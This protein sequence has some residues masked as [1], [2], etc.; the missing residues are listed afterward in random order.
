[1]R[2]SIIRMLFRNILVAKLN[3]KRA[4][5]HCRE[6]V[7]LQRGD[8][9]AWLIYILNYL[10]VFFHQN[11]TMYY[12]L[13]KQNLHKCPLLFKDFFI[14]Q[15]SPQLYFAFSHTLQVPCQPPSLL[16]NGNTHLICHSQHTSCNPWHDSRLMLKRMIIPVL[17]LFL[18]S[19][20]YG[21]Q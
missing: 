10:Y 11:K 13:N 2:T 14:S 7:G 1:M 18:A 3:L 20:G 5:N 16:R 4:R 6:G 17:T 19:V 12:F 8:S 9:R 21:I 15:T